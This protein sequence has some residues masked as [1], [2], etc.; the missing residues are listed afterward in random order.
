[1]RAEKVKP[2]KRDEL[3]KRRLGLEDQRKK[4]QSFEKY[5]LVRG[6]DG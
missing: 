4:A 5:R 3:R 2:C 1:M 6:G